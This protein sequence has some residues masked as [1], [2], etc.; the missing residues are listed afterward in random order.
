M[1]KKTPNHVELDV[2]EYDIVS[3]HYSYACDI[4]S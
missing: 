2:D 3:I 1:H 4:G